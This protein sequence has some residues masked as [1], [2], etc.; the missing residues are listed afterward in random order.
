MGSVLVTGGAGYLGSLVV[1]R[2]V[3]QGVRTIALDIR[4][5]RQARQGVVEVTGDLRSLDLAGLLDEQ[6]VDAVVHL[7]AIVEP[8]RGM[9]DQELAD[10]EVGGTSRVLEACL[11]A[12]VTHLTVT[13]SGAAYGYHARNDGRLLGEDEPVIGSPEFAYSRH[14]AQVEALLAHARRVH[15][16]LG[17]L[18][19]RPGT[20][21][22]AGTDN[23]IT[24]LFTGRV[25]LGL[26]GA[27]S[28]FTF[29]WDQDVAQVIVRGVLERRTGIFNVA[30]EGVL[31]LREIAARTGARLV[32]V[33]P[34]AVRRALGL[35]SRLGMLR[36]GP[37]QVDFLR[38]RPVQDITRLRRAFPGLPSK[39]TREVF[40][41]YWAARQAR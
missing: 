22:G 26:R 34:D 12:G 41:M 10:I 15:P 3:D 8:P 6:A 4:P 40:E 29:V 27:A 20:I 24:A 2:L 37:E 19:L 17:Q 16:Q 36:Y 9:S 25:M 18:V 35:G 13:S 23:Q 14:K 33:P 21:L 31:T 7:A 39:T 1:T 30:G 38:H 28:P 11:A 5:P 32:S